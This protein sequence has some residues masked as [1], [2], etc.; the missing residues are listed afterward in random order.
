MTK[1]RCV[2]GRDYSESTNQ[3]VY[4]KVN[5]KIKKLVEILKNIC[6]ICGR[7]KSQIFIK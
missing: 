5:P 4:K 3:N 7:K 1:T 2:G 6:C